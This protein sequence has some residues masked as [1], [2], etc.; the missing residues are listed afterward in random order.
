MSGTEGRSLRLEAIKIRLT[1]ETA[2]KYDI[3]YR[4][5]AQNN[6]WLDWASNG[7]AAGTE[8]Y[9]YRLEAIEI[10]LVEKGGAAP[11]PT[12]KPFVKK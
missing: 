11:G 9:G 4:V 7:K 6:G 10:L 5:H 3:Y 12:T 2:E 8:G 1:G